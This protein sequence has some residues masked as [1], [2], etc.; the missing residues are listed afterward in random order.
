[1]QSTSTFP[2]GND[3]AARYYTFTSTTMQ[4]FASVDGAS[5]PPQLYTRAGNVLTFYI[6]PSGSS[7]PVPVGTLTIT[8]LTANDLTLFSAQDSSAPSYGYTSYENHYT[9]R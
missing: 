1:M 8:Q 7:A 5:A 9:R 2:I 4:L 3:A 6:N